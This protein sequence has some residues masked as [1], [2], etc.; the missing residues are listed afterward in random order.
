VK[1]GKVY[2]DRSHLPTLGLNSRAVATAQEENLANVGG[3]ETEPAQV[4]PD[5]VLGW[6]G[7]G[8]SIF[9]NVIGPIVGSEGGQLVGTQGTA[10][11][12]QAGTLVVS[13]PSTGS[14]AVVEARGFIVPIT[15]GAIALVGL[16]LV[17]AFRR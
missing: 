3:T 4:S 6:V 15:I 9:S 1:F 5:Q 7:Q 17:V 13:D 2:P 14:S 8:F 16:L 11:P 12:A 10:P